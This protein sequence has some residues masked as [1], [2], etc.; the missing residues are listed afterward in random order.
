MPRPLNRAFTL[1]ELLVVISIIALLIGIL[2]PALSAARQT[3]INVQCLNSIRQLMLSQVMYGNDNDGFL[4]YGT[5]TVVWQKRL[6]PYLPQLSNAPGG[7]A[8]F[9]SMDKDFILAC[10]AR[11]DNVGDYDDP[12]YWQ[13]DGFTYG[14]NAFMELNGGDAGLWRYKIDAV[15]NPST[16]IALGDLMERNSAFIFAPEHLGYG[17]WGSGPGW[18]HGGESGRDTLPNGAFVWRTVSG[19]NTQLEQVQ[20]IPNN[21]NM[22]YMDGHAASTT[23]EDLKFNTDDP[24]SDPWRWAVWW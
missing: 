6:Y 12:D 11:R 24:L 1:I 7:G 14:L 22:A 2:L 8:G 21:A 5:G 13:K 19:D 3:A 15:P 10:P 17:N 16:I 20:N 18:R 9:G 4:T 23:F